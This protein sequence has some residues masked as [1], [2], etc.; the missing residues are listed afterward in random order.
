MSLVCKMTDYAIPAGWTRGELLALSRGA[1][2][3]TFARAH[4]TLTNDPHFQVEGNSATLSFPDSEQAQN[5]TGWWYDKAH[6]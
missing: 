3:Y 5:F 1:E 6:R 2:G 4:P